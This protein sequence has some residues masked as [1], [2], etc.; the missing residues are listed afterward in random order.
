MAQALR[1]HGKENFDF[2]IVFIAKLPNDVLEMFAAERRAFSR[3]PGGVVLML[4][5]KLAALALAVSPLSPAIAN[6]AAS[7]RL[8]CNSPGGS[9]TEIRLVEGAPGLVTVYSAGAAF[10]VSK[11]EVAPLFLNQPE[12]MNGKTVAAKDVANVAL[13]FVN[14]GQGDYGRPILY[15]SMKVPQNGKVVVGVLGQCTLAP[16]YGY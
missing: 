11:A 6:A 1:A 13:M 9:S 8:L 10:N 3:R 2:G 12:K 15:T 16:R 4:V 5:S 7:T 14:A